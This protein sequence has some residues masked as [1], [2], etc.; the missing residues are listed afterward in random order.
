MRSMTAKRHR[1]LII[2]S[3]D[4]P[5]I[6]DR[7]KEALRD[8]DVEIVV[9]RRQPRSA[10]GGDWPQDR[11][12]QQGIDNEIQTRQYVIIQRRQRNGIAFV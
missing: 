3:R 1:Y 9:D 8:E 10:A 7:L 12:R 4:R 5:E 6:C 11:R 2:V